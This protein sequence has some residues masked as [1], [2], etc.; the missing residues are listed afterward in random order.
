[1]TRFRVLGTL[2]VHTTRNPVRL[3][4]PKQRLV[5]GLLLANPGRLVSTDRLIDGLWGESPPHAAKNSL[6]SYVSNLRKAL[7][8]AGLIEGRDGGYVL[9]VDDGDVDAGVFE[10]MVDEARRELPEDPE[11]AVRRLEASL[12]LWRGEPYE[13]LGYEDALQPEIRRLNEVRLGALELRIE[14]QLAAGRHADVIADLEGQTARH[15]TRER[16]WGQLMEALY[17]A[18]RQAEALRTYQRAKAALAQELGIEPGPELRRLEE[19]ILGQDP[20]LLGESPRA[21]NPYRGLGSFTEADGD[22][23]FGRRR[24][25]DRLVALLSG[26]GLESRLVVLTGPS[27]GGKTS[28]VRAGLIPALRGEAIPGSDTWRIVTTFPGADPYRQLAGSLARDVPQESDVRSPAGPI[29]SLRS[30]DTP[31]LIFVDQFE[32]VWTLVEDPMARRRYVADLIELVRVNPNLRVLVAIRSDFLDRLVADPAAAPILDEVLVVLPPLTD[33][34]LTSAVTEP[35]RAAGIGLDADLVFR[36]V[37]DA[38]GRTGALPL[39]QY[40]MTELFE[41]SDAGAITMADYEEAGGVAGALSRRAEDLFLGLPDRAQQTARDLFLRLVTITEAGEVAKRRMPAS[42]LAQA[43]AEPKLVERV[44]DEYG[45]HR[46]L[47]FDRDPDGNPTVDIAHESLLDEWARLRGWITSHADDLRTRARL[48]VAIAEWIESGK[49]ESY[50]LSGSRLV[51][52][53]RWSETTD[54]VPTEAEASFLTASRNAREAGVRRAARLRWTVISLL[55]A[56]AVV[57][58][59]FAV[60]AST[61]RSHAQEARDQADA[62][63]LAAAAAAQIDDDPQLALLLAIQAAEAFAQLGGESSSGELVAVLHDAVGANRALASLDAGG[64]V[65]YSPNGERIAALVGIT[66]AGSSVEAGAEIGVFDAST[67]RRLMSLPLADRN[68]AD[69]TYGGS[70]AMIAAAS[71]DPDTPS[72]DGRVSVWNEAGELITELAIPEGVPDNPTFGAG[73]HF[74]VNVVDLQSGRW[75]HTAVFDTASWQEEFLVPIE[76]FAGVAFAGDGTLAVPHGGRGVVEVFDAATGETVAELE[77]GPFPVGAA[78]A[79]DGDRLATVSLEPPGSLKLWD[80]RQRRVVAS[81]TTR[82]AVLSIAWS[83][84]GGS[85]A[86]AGP[87]GVITLWDPTTAT[88]FATLRGHRGGLNAVRSAISYHP[89]GGR[90]ASADLERTIIWRVGPGPAPEIASIAAHDPSGPSEAAYFADADTVVSLSATELARIDLARGRVMSAT[91]ITSDPALEFFI[92]DQQG[93]L[94]ARADITA[95]RPP[96]LI[97]IGTGEILMVLADAGG[98]V[99]FDDAGRL[100]VASGPGST[101]PGVVVDTG[102]GAVVM[103]TPI[104][105]EV[106]GIEVADFDSDGRRL[107]VG[108]TAGVVSLW[109]VETG[110][111]L[112][113]L[114]HL[115]FITALAF[116]RAGT[117]LVTADVSGAVNVWDVAAIA[118]GGDGQPSPIRALAFPAGHALSAGFTPDGDVAASGFTESVTVWDVA[119]GAER[120]DIEIG[121]PGWTIDFSPDGARM[122][123]PGPEGTVR[124]YA[125]R[126]DDLV[127][128]ARSLVIRGFTEAECARFRIDPCLPI[129]KATD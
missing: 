84:D 78:F 57:A 30:L 100:L 71:F 7:G 68:I 17:R 73:G 37:D 113:V 112:G 60:V 63:R 34:E 55:A 13:D 129:E 46:F 62:E 83:P 121:A 77:H 44:L 6:Q 94:A 33:D 23:F 64:F 109:D 118:S 103:H 87:D 89:S 98:P 18:G 82:T 54:L 38:R 91:Q 114:E 111:L 79:P 88:P 86:T 127:E 105:A 36:V 126:R 35:A 75:L 119:T 20:A 14:A 108:H 43:G 95:S 128:I 45:Q 81:A 104:D 31:A 76:T 65:A 102:T 61:Q 56:A 122:V 51:E 39:L 28:V 4:G 9:A 29:E 93:R 115:G 15:P 2:E 106:Q 16:F 22:V 50:L 1:M 124:V 5:L 97:D 52:I 85:I 67:G 117:R 69:L 49:D 92:A 80:V 59:V 48:G 47:V 74:S 53:D 116:D 8:D 42:E 12:D 21:S 3:G 66:G 58:V 90:L 19:R 25:T 96:E 110:R 125:M 40:V 72:F 123:V 99:A 26:R 120:Y 10:R 11:A 101:R 27:G 32:E 24:F 70:P 107:A 41:R